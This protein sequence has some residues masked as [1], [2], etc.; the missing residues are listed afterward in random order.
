M[1]P[2][3]RLRGAP[4]PKPAVSHEP[5]HKKMTWEELQAA[6]ADE[7][8]LKMF[9]EKAA[10]TT[11]MANFFIEQF[12]TQRF[13]RCPAPH[14]SLLV[15]RPFKMLLHGPRVDGDRCLE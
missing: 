3:R 5:K 13:M 4:A 14:G 12:S 2:G 1:E 7:P 10:G 11:A 9:A 6:L 15:E 8:D